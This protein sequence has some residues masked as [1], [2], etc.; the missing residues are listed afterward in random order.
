MK[1]VTAAVLTLTI[2]MSAHAAFKIESKTL[3]TGRREVLS[4]VKSM[5]KMNRA[6]RTAMAERMLKL[7]PKINQMVAEEALKTEIETEDGKKF[8]LEDLNRTIETYAEA[9][10]QIRETAKTEKEI[11]I[12]NLLSK[13]QTAFPAFIANS[14]KMGKGNGNNIKV[15]KHLL[16][17]LP[18]AMSYYGETN[19]KDLESFIKVVEVANDRMA[20]K[21]AEEITFEDA[22]AFAV[23][24]NKGLAVNGKIKDPG[25]LEE[26][27]KEIL[28]CK[29]R[30]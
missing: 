7:N 11:A 8:R 26:E 4:V 15:A 14:V 10:P 5:E 2:A 30:G 23:A 12:G 13:A 6:S 21:Q 28:R 29:R 9:I 24:D 25:Q 22:V 19:I 18:D 3:D 1:N 16:S 17:L 27:L 20:E